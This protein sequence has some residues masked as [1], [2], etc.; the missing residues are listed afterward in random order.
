MEEKNIEVIT[1]EKE[2]EKVEVINNK[3]ETQ[4]SESKGMSV[5]ALVLGIVSVVFCSVGLV[6]IACGVLAIIFGI[7][8]KKRNGKG[9]AQAGFILGIIGLS[10][11]AILFIFGFI[12]GMGLFA[13][14]ISAM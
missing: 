2:Q 9:M 12:I 13:A 10:L 6:N 1:N 11:R 14:I 8:G 3:E 4:K 7:K 5:A